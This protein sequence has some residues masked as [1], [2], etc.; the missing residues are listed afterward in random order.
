MTKTDVEMLINEN[1]QLKLELQKLK[2]SDFYTEFSHND[3]NDNT[4]QTDK[5]EPLSKATPL[6]KRLKNISKDLG[7]L[8]SYDI[9]A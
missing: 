4:T 5:D 3:H 9:N 7:S 8:K 2:S 1:K 6:K